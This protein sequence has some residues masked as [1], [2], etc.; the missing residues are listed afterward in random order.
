[1][2]AYMC[3]PATTHV[4]GSEDNFQESALFFHTVGFWT[5]T[6]V[7][8]YDTKHLYLLSHLSSSEK[9]KM[10]FD[11]LNSLSKSQKNIKNSYISF[12]PA[13]YPFKFAARPAAL[14]ALL[15]DYSK[16]DRLST[17]KQLLIW[18]RIIG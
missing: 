5:R 17:V 14:E 15:A 9:K 7:I 18:G 16:L 6:Q 10:L 12:S 3:A 1:M 2:H 13:V 4:S 8:G 11:W